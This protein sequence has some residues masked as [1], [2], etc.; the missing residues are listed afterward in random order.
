MSKYIGPQHKACRRAGIKL[1]TSLKC[2]MTKRNYPP[3][4][5]GPKGYPRLTAY[6]IQLQEKQKAK[7]VYGILERQFKNLVLKAR[8]KTGDTGEHLLNFLE[9]RL[10]NVVYRLG[11]ASTRRQA[12]QL[13][14]HGHFLVDGKS[15]TIPSYLLRI[16]QTVTLK[17]SS[18]NLSFFKNV[19]V[20]LP[21]HKVSAWLTLDPQKAEGK[22]AAYAG[23][24]REM[25]P[26]FDVK[27]VVEY[28]SR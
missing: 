28:Y 8:R 6:G 1:C 15:V 2:P 20:N 22:M 25:K 18:K 24:L 19:I 17:E 7:R 12:R 10:D 11:F 13:V 23:T 16:G 5:H 9:S 21:S 26:L 4:V 14:N 3:G 27:V